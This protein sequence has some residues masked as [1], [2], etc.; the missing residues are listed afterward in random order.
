MHGRRT[1]EIERGMETKEGKGE[2]P[3]IISA[4]SFQDV[5]IHIYYGLLLRVLVSVYTDGRGLLDGYLLT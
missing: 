5:W 3:F 2:C 4:R 1:S